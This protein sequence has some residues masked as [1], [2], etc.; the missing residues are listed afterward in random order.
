MT[1]DPMINQPEPPLYI[2][3]DVLIQQLTTKLSDLETKVSNYEKLTQD[4]RN[5]VRDLYT[6]LNDVIQSDELDESSD[7]TFGDL[8]IILNDVFGSELVF[9]KEYEVQV[10]YNVT[11]TFSIKAQSEDDAR[12]IAEEISID[13]E[14]RFDMDSDTTDVTEVVSELDRIYYVGKAN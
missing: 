4:H 3:P 13:D 5:K 6:Q 14:P 9:L 12:S 2:A 10:T 8:S 1:T 11:A 7:I